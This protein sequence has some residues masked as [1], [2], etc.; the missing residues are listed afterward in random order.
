MQMFGMWGGE[1][2]FDTAVLSWPWGSTKELE[3]IQKKSTGQE[4]LQDIWNS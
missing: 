1:N 4:M 3:F 2:K